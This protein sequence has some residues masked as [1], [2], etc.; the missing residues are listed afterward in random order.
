VLNGNT[1]NVSKRFTIKWGNK[2]EEEKVVGTDIPVP[3][4][5]E[6][7]GEVDLEVIYSTEKT[8]AKEQF[9]DLLVPSSGHIVGVNM[10][11]GGKDSTGASATYSLTGAAYA[12]VMEWRLIG[13]SVA[14]A[15]LHLR[16]GARPAYLQ[17]GPV[18]IRFGLDT[19]A[20]FGFPSACPITLDVIG[21]LD[22]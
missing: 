6:F 8:A 18:C 17:A 2:Q 16:I 15:R 12:E 13:P 1:Y 3:T 22:T 4:T 19:P 14:K 10:T 20:A 11:W 21:G 9:A 5:A 7:H